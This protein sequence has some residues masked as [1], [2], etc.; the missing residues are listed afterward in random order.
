MSK[1]ENHQPCLMIA[2]KRSIAINPLA[3]DPADLESEI[4]H[5]STIF[6]FSVIYF[7]T[8]RGHPRTPETP[9]TLRASILVDRAGFEPAAFRSPEE[10]IPPCEPDVLRPRQPTTAQ[11][12]RLNY[13]PNPTSARPRN[14]LKDFRHRQD[15]PNPEN[16]N[17]RQSPARKTNGPVAQHG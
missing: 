9:H 1:K 5:F 7:S 8:P 11:H 16:V 13:R 17:T 4:F 2:D 3:T 6:S 10:N 12:T 14:H 15:P